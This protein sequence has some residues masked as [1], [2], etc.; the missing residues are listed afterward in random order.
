M[1]SISRRYFCFTLAGAAV[2]AAGTAALG[3]MALAKAPE[4][5]GT[6]PI[7]DI[8]TLL[9]PM[10][11]N[12]LTLFSPHNGATK[13]IGLPDIVP[14]SVITA[15]ALGSIAYVAGRRGLAMLEISSAKV[16]GTVMPSAGMVFSG[17]G[18]LTADGKRLLLC[19]R[20]RGYEKPGEISVRDSSSLRELNRFSTTCRNP[21]SVALAE[22]EGHL[23]VGHRG[24]RGQQGEALWPADLSYHDLQT[25]KVIKSVVPRD[26]FWGASHFDLGQEGEVVVS[27]QHFFE[28][29][30][31]SP[32]GPYEEEFVFPTPLM[33]GK[34][35]AENWDYIM[36]QEV[37]LRM[38][39]GHSIRVD[40][41]RNR[42]IV[43]HDAGNL[44]S[45][46][47][48]KTRKLISHANIQRPSG[49]EIS[50]DGRYYIVVTR[51]CDIHLLSP[52][53][54][55]VLHSLKNT[56]LNPDKIGPDH[57]AIV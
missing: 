29:Q 34:K 30:G 27:T 31:E 20:Y 26:P 45:L 24:V 37:K 32:A 4:K 11:D 49:I 10:Q 28:L 36:P 35:D 38:K 42:F 19:E 1:D 22:Q 14:H 7:P 46:V 51:D 54:L 8:G 56:N 17:H 47:D 23:I 18:C 16:I 55:S 33:I 2:A 12:R 21:I 6:K 48:I 5:R 39:L 53:N 9:I 40:R 52:E 3:P 25:G 50:R 44:V 57:I 13:T 43:V 41:A 15:S